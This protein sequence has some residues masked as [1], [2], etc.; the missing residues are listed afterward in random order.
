MEANTNSRK[1]RFE[2]FMEAGGVS[3][4]TMTGIVAILMLVRILGRFV[5]LCRESSLLFITTVVFSFTESQILGRI[6]HATRRYPGHGGKK[7]K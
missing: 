1:A 6:R 2:E 3:R 5:R 7:R 4:T